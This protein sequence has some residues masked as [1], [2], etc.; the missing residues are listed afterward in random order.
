M[1]PLTVYNHMDAVIMFCDWAPDPPRK[2]YVFRSKLHNYII[3]I[4]KQDT[5]RLSHMQGGKLFCRGKFTEVLVGRADHRSVFFLDSN[6]KNTRVE[7][8]KHLVS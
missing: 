6:Y 5:V 4:S 1:Y 8:D 2:S 7:G 3:A